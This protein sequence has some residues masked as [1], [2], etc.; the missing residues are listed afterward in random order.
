MA[1]PREESSRARSESYKSYEK[2][3]EPFNA[4]LK[5]LHLFCLNVN[6]REW[7]TRGSQAQPADP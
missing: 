1:T 5:L 7:P 2:A 6:D 4:E 3:H